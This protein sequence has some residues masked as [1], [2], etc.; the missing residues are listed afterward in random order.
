M[1]FNVADD[2][3]ELHIIDINAILATEVEIPIGLFTENTQ[4]V[5]QVSED[6]PVK[7]TL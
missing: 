2:N 3:V 4:A 1:K 6:K 7:I 5:L